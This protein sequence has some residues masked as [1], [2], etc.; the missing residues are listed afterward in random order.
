MEDED[1]FSQWRVWILRTLERLAT[2]VDALKRIVGD[3]EE[4]VRR[5][6]SVETDMRRLRDLIETLN[7]SAAVT[8]R[9]LAIWS[10]IAAI[11]G[12]VVGL[13]L[14]HLVHLVER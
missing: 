12:S 8:R 6:E 10:S 5:F 1:N 7:V 3:R 14:P 2:D 13:I 11:V 4:Y 9:T